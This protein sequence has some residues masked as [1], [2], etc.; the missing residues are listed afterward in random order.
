MRIGVVEFGDQRLTFNYRVGHGTPLV[1]LH[2]TTG[3][4][5]NWDEVIARLDPTRHVVCVNARG[6]GSSGRCGSRPASYE[7]YEGTPLVEA[8]RQFSAPTRA[9]RLI[10]HRRRAGGDRLSGPHRPRRDRAGVV[11]HR[12]GHRQHDGGSL[13]THQHAVPRGLP[14]DQGFRRPSVHGRPGHLSHHD[15]MSGARS[16]SE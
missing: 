11:G 12:R 2:G 15:G 1:F 10:Q 16:V 6:H 3:H 14:P 7:R 9:T 13:S 5:Q 8:L 4:A